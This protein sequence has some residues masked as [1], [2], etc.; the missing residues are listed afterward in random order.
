MPNI[1]TIRSYINSANWDGL[2]EKFG[3]MSNA[4]FRRIEASIRDLV[5]PY[6]SN[7]QFWDTYLHLLTYRRQAFLSSILAIRRLSKSGELD[8][9]CV[10]AQDVAKWIH[11]NTPESAA[12]IV[13]MAVPL[14][15]DSRQITALFQW[16]NFTDSREII[17]ILT[18]E[19]SPQTYHALFQYLRHEGDNQSLQRMACITL[20]RRSDDLSFNMAS[21]LRSYFDITDINSTFSLRIEPHEL[22]YIDQSYSNFAHVLQ[23]RRPV[24]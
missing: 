3:R 15:A 18:K 14:L 16:M 4:E 7:S 5:L 6:L 10:E 24:L 19:P 21:I 20:M 8:F 9:R 11:A 17:A 22:S 1:D 2:Y 13:R 12:K 23:G